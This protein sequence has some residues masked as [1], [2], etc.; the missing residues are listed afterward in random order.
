MVFIKI[1]TVI[2]MYNLLSCTVFK[3]LWRN[4]SELHKVM[5]KQTLGNFRVFI[6]KRLLSSS[7]VFRYK[8]MGL[9]RLFYGRVK[10]TWDILSLY[11]NIQLTCD[12]VLAS[13]PW[14]INMFSLSISLFLFLLQI[15]TLFTLKPTHTFPFPSISHLSINLHIFPASYLS[16]YFPFITSYHLS[17]CLYTDLL[18]L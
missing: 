15:F 6:P 4:V 8:T 2:W 14:L 11:L 1:P 5:E 10:R 17:W 12:T 16:L 13:Q 18:G 9:I 3:R 7:G